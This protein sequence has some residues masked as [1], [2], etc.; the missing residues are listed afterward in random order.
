MQDLYHQQYDY[1]Y[2]P[3]DLGYAQMTTAISISMIMGMVVIA[4]FMI[5]TTVVT[6]I[7]AVIVVIF[8]F[9]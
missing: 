6:M 3:Y 8:N 5:A 9:L 7:T 4:I 2:P 1:Y